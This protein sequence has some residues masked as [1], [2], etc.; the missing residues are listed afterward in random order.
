[1]SSKQ[2]CRYTFA[3]SLSSVAFII[4]IYIMGACMYVQI[5]LCIY[6]QVHFNIARYNV[7]NRVKE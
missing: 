5:Q 1:M 2:V 6:I 3:K 7:G 4:I